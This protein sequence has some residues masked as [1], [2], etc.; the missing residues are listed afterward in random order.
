MENEGCR[1]YRR[2]GLRMTGLG[3]SCAKHASPTCF[4]TIFVSERIEKKYK[5]KLN[6]I[7]LI[8]NTME[9]ILFEELIMTDLLR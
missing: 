7:I 1:W 2:K 3:T 8:F 9:Q 4:V 5:W 6:L